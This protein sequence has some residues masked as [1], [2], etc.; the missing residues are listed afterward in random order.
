VASRHCIG[1]IPSRYAGPV[2]VTR[3]L[4]RLGT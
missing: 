4:A 1:A 3:F 2:V